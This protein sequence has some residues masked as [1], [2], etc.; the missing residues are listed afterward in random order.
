M[1][2]VHGEQEEQCHL[3]RGCVKLA[4]YNAVIKLAP[5]C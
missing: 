2:N 1:N 3:K 4:F 5:A